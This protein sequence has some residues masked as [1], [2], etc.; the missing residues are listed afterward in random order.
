MVKDCGGPTEEG[1]TYASHP[2]PPVLCMHNRIMMP[3]ERAFPSA[4]LLHSSFKILETS[5]FLL[6]ILICFSPF[7][8]E[9]IAL[10]H[11]QGFLL[12]ANASSS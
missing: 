2:S 10:N 11:N 4:I 8:H 7:Y 5:V 1:V 6:K 9:A 12:I 3:A